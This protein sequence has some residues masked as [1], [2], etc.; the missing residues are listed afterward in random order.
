MCFV[1]CVFVGVFF[2]LRGVCLCLGFCV[3]CVAFSSPFM[4][5]A[6][7]VVVCV[8][9]VCDALLP[10]WC[11]AV[12]LRGFV[13]VCVLCFAMCDVC[14]VLCVVCIVVCDPCFA[15]CGLFLCEVCCVLCVGCCVV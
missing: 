14:I 10:W 6:V 1:G 4:H 9:T 2:C 5:Y 3:M 12:L 15:M 13:F 11:V 7:C 8:S